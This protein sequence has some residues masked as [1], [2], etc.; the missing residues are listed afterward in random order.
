MSVSAPTAVAT[1]VP[2]LVVDS[3][4][5]SNLFEVRDAATSLETARAQVVA[6]EARK[7]AI[8]AELE[9]Q[10]VDPWLAAIGGVMPPGQA[11][12]IG[13]L[14]VAPLPAMAPLAPTTYAAQPPIEEIPQPQ[15]PF[16]CIARRQEA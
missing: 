12:G 1:A 14:G 16:A 8:D 2:A 9:A 15:E 10:A 3:L 11:P 7:S 5:V 4:A 13:H 6:L